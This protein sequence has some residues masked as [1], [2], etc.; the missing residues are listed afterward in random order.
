[1][2]DDL[3]DRATRALRAADD[4]PG[5]PAKQAILHH[6]EGERRTRARRLAVLVP[7]AAVVDPS[8]RAPYVLALDD[9][10]RVRRAPVTP[11]RLA[12]GWVSV[13]GEGLAPG[14]RVVT[15]G[16]GRLEAGMRV[17]VLP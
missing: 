17:R 5:L 9:D 12:G 10:D 11:G 4:A 2:S 15:A 14:D 8:G 7:L 6:I 1:M 13:N 3:L 16:Q